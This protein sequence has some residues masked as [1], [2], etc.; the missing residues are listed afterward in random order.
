MQKR[1]RLLH[2][3]RGFHHLRQEHLA[4]AEQIADHV[5]ARHQRALDHIERPGRE[6]ARLFH[7]RLD[8]FGDAVDE[9]M[10]EPLLDAPRAPGEIG[11]PL[12]HAAAAAILLRQ[13]EQPVGRVGAA[14]E[15]H[16]LAGRAQLRIQVVINRQLPGIDDAEVHT[17]VDRVKQEYRVHRLA[18]RLVA[19]ERKGK[20]RDAAG[21]MRVRQPGADEARRFD[22]ID[23]VIGVL[24]DPGRHREDIRIEDNVFGRKAD[25]LG[26]DAV[27]ALGDRGLARQRVGL[28][29]LV[30]GHDHDRGAVAAHQPRVLLERL[31]AL[32]H[33]DRVD[34]ALALHAFQPR[35]DHR[36]LRGVD[37]DRHA[38]D[39]RLGGDKIEERDHRP[40]RIEQAFVHIDVDHLGAVGDL[41]ARHF[42]R[43]RS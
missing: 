28:A 29:L 14:V 41:V 32:L 12:L 37:H 16:V 19:A 22:E 9:R 43:R 21:D 10:L 8:E 35:L 2:H 4:R 27:G 18:H 3:A 1:D 11:L 39:V 17:G 40:L 30:E 36:P 6:L 38:R 25:L 31:L 33:R 34:D 24:L 15:H 7:V 42:E 5:H 23:A 26:Q 13:C 20:V